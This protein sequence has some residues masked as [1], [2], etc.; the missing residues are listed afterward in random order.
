L[1]DPPEQVLFRRLGVFSGGFDLEAIHAVCIT[2]QDS[3][4]MA[5]LV[6]PLVEKS[7]VLPDGGDPNRFWMLETMREFARHRAATTSDNGWLGRKHA[8][9]FLNLIRMHGGKLRAKGARQHL[10]HLDRNID[11]IRTALEWASANDGELL[12]RLALGLHAYWTSRCSF[13]EALI[14]VRL[15]L[16]SKDSP[17][18][19][20]LLASA[21]WLEIT[22]GVV[23]LGL[24]HSRQAL[25]AAEASGDNWGEVRALFNVAEGLASLDDL[26]GAKECLERSVTIAERVK[27]S[28]SGSFQD[29]AL[30]SGA[31]CM[32]AWVQMVSGHLETAQTSLVKGTE[33]AARAGDYF[34]EALGRA[35]HSEIAMAQGDVSNA[36]TLARRGLELGVNIDHRF[37]MVRAIGQL[38]AIA[39]ENDS[40]DQS[41]RLAAAVDSVRSATGAR[42]FE[43]FDFWFGWGWPARLQRVRDRLGP[44]Q[45]ERVWDEGSRLSLY[46]A[47][48]VALGDQSLISQSGSER[49]LPSRI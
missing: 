36:L 39:A 12:A 31:W 3:P 16:D 28:D 35:W 2:S 6:T 18:R 30:R 5:Q 14:W 7:L 19:Q 21:G 13:R 24:E 45:A 37:I 8:E 49:L 33:L 10:A 29:Q 43:K 46:E 25:A 44:G 32:L 11:N 4:A 17:L 40:P 34:C 20:P 22:A 42:G 23:D 38:A 9:H 41:L 15:A 48:A 1:L 26:Q 47:A 27:A